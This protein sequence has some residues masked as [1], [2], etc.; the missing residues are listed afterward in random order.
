M[1]AVLFVETLAQ[2]VLSSSLIVLFGDS[3]R[4]EN[5]RCMNRKNAAHEV[6]GRAPRPE[7]RCLQVSHT[8]QE[9]GMFLGV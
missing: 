1:P 5:R 2:G 4:N 3:T 6:M 7:T 9:K 8:E